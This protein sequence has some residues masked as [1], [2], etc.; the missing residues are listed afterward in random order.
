[1]LGALGPVQPVMNGWAT[2]NGPETLIYL[3]TAKLTC[4][5][6]M[7]MG[8]HWLSK[9]PAKSQVIEIVVPG[10]ASAKMYTVGAPDRA[11]VNY[12]EGSKSSST[13]VVGRAGSVT[14]TKVN[15]KMLY[16]GTIAVTSPFTA[17]GTFHAEWCQGGA[18]Y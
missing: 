1:M 4:P 11:E 2:T 15:A 7:T 10:A 17:S 5:D 12:A 18:E 9:L 13:E 3:A 6:M 8:V 16:E 14:F